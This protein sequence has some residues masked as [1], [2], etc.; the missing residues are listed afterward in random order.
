ME[1]KQYDWALLNEKRSEIDAQLS[2][3]EIKIKKECSQLFTKSTPQGKSTSFLA[4]FER[5]MAIYDGA[6]IGYK[7]YCRFN[8]LFNFFRKIKRNKK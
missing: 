7:L 6:M 8:G 5:I 3:L 4:N 1:Q 2:A